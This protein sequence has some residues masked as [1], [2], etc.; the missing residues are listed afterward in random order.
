M[1]IDDWLGAGAILVETGRRHDLFDLANSGF[2]LGDLGL[3]LVD[4]GATSLGGALTFARLGIGSLLVV[5][6]LD[7]RR[8]RGGRGFRAALLRGARSVLQSC[9]PAI[10]QF[11]V[12]L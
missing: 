12:L 4:F 8:L 10:L 7:Q 11:L 5:A 1:A 9:H 6:R 3:Q 2:A